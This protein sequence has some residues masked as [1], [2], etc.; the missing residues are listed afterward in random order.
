MIEVRDL[1]KIYKLSMGMKKQMKT[2]DTHKRAVSDLSFDVRDGEIFGL[3]GTNGAGKTTT[4]RCISTLLKPTEGHITVNGYDTV[5]D[6]Q[7]VREM[8]SLLTN[9]VKLDPQFTPDYLFDFFGHM[10]GLK[11]D[12]IAKR[13]RELFDYFGV[14]DFADK[15][16]SELS[17]GMTQ[18]ISLSVSMVHDPDVVVFDEPTTGLDIVTARSV[19][20]YLRELRDRGKTIIISTHIMSEA[21]KL[22]DRI[23]IIVDGEKVA[24][25][26]TA[27]LKAASNAADLE[28][29]FFDLYKK[30]SKEAQ[31]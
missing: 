23:A 20:D 18:K 26:T 29:V 19:L 2:K 10:R 24:E 3:L 28:E 30:F 7:K 8:L 15:K 14:N 12:V 1:T 6:A 5:K 31:Q 9:D 22:C 4:L 25:G 13:K 21:E 27:E 16:V 11:G 17:T